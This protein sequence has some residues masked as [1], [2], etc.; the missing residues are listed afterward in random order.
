MTLLKLGRPVAILA[1]VAVALA[2]GAAGARTHHH[3]HG[4]IA[5]H[6][7]GH[8]GHKLAKATQGGARVEK[9]ADRHV[10]RHAALCETVM[11]HRRWVT[12]CRGEK[13]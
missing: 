12:H 6:R 7:R 13:S 3:H 1:A 10:R 5:S 9:A 8:H 2:P 11:V 4:Q